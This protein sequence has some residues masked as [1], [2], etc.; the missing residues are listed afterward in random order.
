MKNKTKNFGFRIYKIWQ[1]LK[2]FSRHLIAHPDF[3]KSELTMSYIIV[4]LLKYLASRRSLPALLPKKCDMN[5]SGLGYLF[6]LSKSAFGSS[7]LKRN[8]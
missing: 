2:H 4:R 3:L 5:D 6:W 7:P 1:I 8:A